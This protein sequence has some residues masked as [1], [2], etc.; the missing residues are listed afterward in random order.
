MKLNFIPKLLISV[1][2]NLLFINSFVFANDYE[3]G[4][5]RYFDNFTLD[6]ADEDIQLET[7]AI[8]SDESPNKWDL[9]LDKVISEN[10]IT[11]SL[12][13]ASFFSLPIGVSS[14]ASSSYMIV[15][16]EAS[17][18]EDHAEFSAFMVLTNPLDG[19]KIRFRAKDIAFS[20]DSGLLNG[21]KLELMD[22]RKSKIMKD[23]YLNWLPGC[24]VEWDCNGFK[25]LGINGSIELSKESYVAVNP[26]TGEE[27]GV[28]VAP[29]Y[30]TG[31]DFQNILVEFSLPTF[32]KK[33]F[34][35]VFFSFTS[36]VLDFSDTANAPGFKLPANYPGNY[37]GE[38][39]NLWQG[40]YVKDAVV[41]LAKK[42]NNKTGQMTS[43]YAGEV[44][45]DDF[46]LTGHFGV[47]NLISIENGRLGSWP[48][49]ISNLELEFF[50]GE[51]KSFAI[52]GSV[53]VQGSKTEMI[54]S[55][56]FD[57]EGIY[58]FGINPGKEL[59][60]DVFAAEVELDASS[61][62]EVTV[63]HGKFQPTAILYGKIS[64][65][66][67]KGASGK[68]K[69]LKLPDLDFQGMRISSVAPVFDLE[70]MGMSSGE[71]M[72]FN[73]FPITL[74]DASFKKKGEYEAK[75]IFGIKVNLSKDESIV[76]ATRVG[77]KMGIGTGDWKYKG[78][79]IEMLTVEAQK[80][81]AYTIKGSVE[82]ADGD[83]TYGDGFRGEVQAKFSESFEVQAVAVFGK[84]NGFRYFF[85]DGFVCLPPPGIV[86]GPFIM[87]GFGGGLSSRMRQALPD[88]ASGSMGKSLSGITYIPDKSSFLGIKAGVKAGI[89]NEK[90]VNCVVN[91]EVIFNNHG[92]INQIG[93]FGE[94]KI[95]SIMEDLPIDKMKE[96]AQK[97]ALGETQEVATNEVMR[98][99][100]S[101]LQDFQNHTFH[102][103]MELFVNVAG[104][105]TGI[106]ANNRAGWGVMHIE[107]GKWYL[108][109][110]TPTDPIGLN[111][112]GFMKVG[113]YFMAGY[114]IPDAMVMNPKVLEYLNISQEKID[115]NRLEGNLAMGKGL[116]FGANFSLDTGDL[117]FLIFYARFELGGGFDVMLL[118]YGKYAYCRGRDGDLGLNGWYAKGQAYAYFG[119]KIGI[120]VKV[121]GR[122]KKF[123]II[124][125]RTAAAI[126]VEGPNPTFMWGAVGG[127][128]RILGGLIKGK[129]KFEMTVGEK[130]D[131]QTN[132]KELSDMEI[133]ADLSPM[134]DASKVDV[135]TLP[136]AVFNM[137]VDKVLK[138]SED[139]GLTKVFKIN[140]KEY[141]LSK[142]G[143]ILEGQIEWDGEHTTLAFTPDMM[144]YPDSKYKIV[145][146]VSFDEKIDGVWQEYK[147]ES[148][149]VYVETKE[150]EFTTGELPEQIP[151]NYISYTY[152]IDKQVHFYKDEYS[153]AYV[154]F[155][156][157]LTP[158]FVPVEGWTKKVKWSAV[159]GASFYSDLSYN[160]SNKSV[161]ISGSEKLNLA[162]VYR[163][164]L[165]NTP[166]DD[167]VVVNRNVSEST[168]TEIAEGENTANITT[169][170]ATGTIS[171]V[172]E[173]AFYGL[174][175]RT[176]KYNKFLDKV[177]KTELNVRFL[178]NICPA[179][180]FLGATFYSDE[181]FD[182]YE[183]YGK[184]NVEVLIKRE[185]VLET[186]DWYQANIY[187][188]MYK[189]YP[190]HSKAQI[191]NRNPSILGIPPTKSIDFWQLNDHYLLNETD[192]SLGQ[193][194]L[195]DDKTHFVYTLPQ[196]WAR[197][198]YDIRNGLANLVAN[199]FSPDSRMNSILLK[200]PWPQVS[201]GNYP[202]KLEY[203]LP[204]R[205]IVTSTR[206]INLK[207]K[208]K[209]RQINLLDVEF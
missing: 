8:V 98:A 168:N 147:D 207:N 75:F 174:D 204:G 177:N 196:I 94:A 108:H 197:D 181:M 118:D 52:G 115:G 23:T 198:Y 182:E 148:G 61:R 79:V 206:I 30:A 155:K 93:F 50:T 17:V 158:F 68:K 114:D 152:P 189:G 74:T 199:G 159:N 55:A 54:Y 164:D 40:L 32:K 63:D 41:T 109:M 31:S 89:V 96:I 46:G 193:V 88:E 82:F 9:I 10:R 205:K 145:T 77:I 19:T 104:V 39:K 103:E 59:S 154:T 208:F 130:C 48:M 184:G 15:I 4:S 29:I 76:G 137:P 119:G 99:T 202:I 105:F 165:V 116:A 129:C 162:T 71:E 200:Y 85:V 13:E 150:A 16:D 26:E 87:Q 83:N 209:V 195:K 142:D 72:S 65:A 37:S 169:R 20:F 100:V 101:I 49:S 38:M 113:G 62:I 151:E 153:S 192:I 7:A 11:S 25:S 57:S 111:F 33:D 122:R 123:D 178:H 156:S 1:L 140:L 12:T 176:S 121:F 21:M 127:S 157:D 70:Y 125:I 80:E 187:P 92:G 110:G 67:S 201:A 136:Q 160:P 179:V 146:K 175:F 6:Q 43:F 133:I 180:D 149:K 18:Y 84:V 42:F 144:F 203:V 120:K 126:R 22:T 60:F 166:I 138:I 95:M 190:L 51:F 139:K 131:I 107:P 34:D 78:L 24:F 86:A 28:V 66:A 171:N 163:L 27:S 45:L 102:S 73:K 69:I 117:K 170:E 106:G 112:I 167:D 135:F 191:R 47:E 143:T 186:A 194:R 141:S 53:I 173:K 134:N 36:V 3:V 56:F 188:L 124:D 185:A 183:I 5:V 81:G 161:E 91:F 35:E 128:Y 97:A 44:L 2:F 90:I 172:E 64:F 132:P 58:H 14:G